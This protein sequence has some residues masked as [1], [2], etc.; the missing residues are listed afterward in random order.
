M[1]RAVRVVAE[2]TW[3]FLGDTPGAWHTSAPFRSPRPPLAP[4]LVQPASPVC[5]FPAVFHVRRFCLARGA[6]GNHRCGGGLRGGA[7]RR[8]SEVANERGGQ[9]INTRTQTHF[10]WWCIRTRRRCSQL[11]RKVVKDS[12]GCGE[13]H[14]D[15]GRQLSIAR[16]PGGTALAP[17][18]AERPGWSGRVARPAQSRLLDRTAADPET[19][20]WPPAAAISDPGGHRCGDRACPL[21]PPL[22]SPPASRGRGDLGARSTDAAGSSVPSLHL[23][24]A[25]RLALAPRGA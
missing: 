10:F 14:G 24:P 1:C 5:H 8:D 4:P 7:A 16:G 17:A 23:G 11:P 6:I 9:Q 21:L 3:G 12:S 13:G 25:R 18:A 20:A 2:R 15:G 19:A 22:S